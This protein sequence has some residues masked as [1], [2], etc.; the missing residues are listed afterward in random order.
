MITR[1]LTSYSPRT[2][3]A[4]MSAVMA[5]LALGVVAPPSAAQCCDPWSDLGQALA[6]T[7]GAPLFEATGSLAEDT[8]VTLSLSEAKE[9][10]ATWLVAG[11]T[12]INAPFKGGVLVPDTALL[13]PLVTDAAGQIELHANWPAGLPAGTNVVLQY[14][15]ADPAGPVGFAASNALLGL[16][17]APPPPGSFP[18]DWINGSNCAGDP[19]IQVH[20]Y[21]ADTY[22]LRQSKCTN[23]EGPFMFLL[24]GQDRVLLLDTGATGGI[25]LALTVNN[26]IANW[27]VAHGRTSIPLTVA[28]THA[29]GD[30]IANDNQFTGQPNTTVVGTSQ[31]SVAAFFGFTNWPNDLRTYELGGRTLDVLAIPGHHSSHIALYDRN[32]AL[33]FTGDTLYPGWLFIS[34]AVSQGNFAKYKASI[35][36]LVDFTADKPVLWVLGNHVEMKS[37]P[38]QAYVYGNAVAPLERD[39]PLLRAHLLELNAAVQ[40]MTTPVQQT[41]AD[42]IITPSG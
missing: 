2:V 6:G 8:Q 31:A 38:F 12:Q 11:L 5:L 17:P 39:H 19:K 35:Q 10:A 37:T 4:L 34:G 40:A 22:I 24:F 3:G 21:D 26:L 13:L 28:H 14:W 18:A 33:L 20:A 23:F 41:H 1:L 30:H 15:I 7:H 42:F 25:P 16:T 27:L 36:R 32:T 29:H 9:S